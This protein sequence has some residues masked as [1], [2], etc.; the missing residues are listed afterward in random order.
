M[1]A[2]ARSQLS[3]RDAVALV[4]GFYF[5]F[6]GGMVSVVFTAELAVASSPR[7]FSTLLCA[8]SLTAM[9]AGAWRLHQVKHLGPEWRK[10]ATALLLTT[11]LLVYLFPFLW[12]WRQIPQSLYFC[13]HALAFL[14][15]LIV[16]MMVMSVVSAALAHALGQKGLRWQLVFSLVS[17]ALIQ[18]APFSYLAHRV[19]SRAIRSEEMILWLQA[20]FVRLHMFWI[21]L[22]LL[23]FTLAL[24][25]V[26]IAKDIALERL[27]G[28]EPEASAPANP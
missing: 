27:L 5:L 23:P 12:A 14:G 25:L 18:L 20:I 4:Q 13:S 3:A 11:A 10:S 26:W 7:P 24:S 21:M 28:L 15:L 16:T 6:F 17:A 8:G 19:A 22:W 1:T 2:A 9:L